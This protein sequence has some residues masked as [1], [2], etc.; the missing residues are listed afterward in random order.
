M[1]LCTLYK[2]GHETLLL[3]ITS[4]IG[5]SV[6]H[7]YLNKSIRI[8]GGGNGFGGSAHGPSTNI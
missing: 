4:I 7:N 1:Q 6:S 5:Y 2:N 3:N 8:S